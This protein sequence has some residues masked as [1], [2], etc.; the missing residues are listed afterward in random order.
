M[1]I[2][3]WREYIM[4]DYLCFT[5]NAANSSVKLVKNGSP[6]AVTLETS[7]DGSTRT[8][9]TIGSTITLSN[10][11]D[12]VYFRNTSET[13]TWFSTSGSNYYRFIL[14]WNIAASWDIN[15]LLCKNSTTTLISNYCYH[16]L[17]YGQSALVSSPQLTAT[18]LTNNCYYEMF[19]DCSNLETLPILP[20]TTLS[21][22][23]YLEMFSWCPKIK[24]SYSQ[25]WEYVNEYKIP[26]T[27]TWTM[28]SNSLTNMFYKT[29]WTFT[30]TPTINTTYYTS[31]QVI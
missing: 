12:K 6:T 27:W 25:T 29:W 23:C 26:I 14:T 18:T 8:A 4:P 17:F 28:W 10:I 31:N 24:L 2:Y 21:T 7:T 11:G 3:M 5:A 22:S 30:W 13:T 20:A 19:N 9:Y 16:Y 15:Y 1:A